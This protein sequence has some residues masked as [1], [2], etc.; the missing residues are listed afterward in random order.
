MK[1]YEKSYRIEAKE[2]SLASL[3]I[4]YIFDL[5]GC[6][7]NSDDF[8]LTNK[9]AYELDKEESHIPT[10]ENK[11]DFSIWYMKKHMMDIPPYLGILSLFVKLSMFSN[12][13]IVTSRF[14]DL[15]PATINW[16]K[17]VIIDNF[18]EEIWRRCKFQIIFN[19]N[20]E[21]SLKFKSRI[22]ENLKEFYKILL[23]VEDHPEVI[24]YAQKQGIEVLVPSTG[25]KNLNGKDLKKRKANVRK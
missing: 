5:D 7:A 18:N 16:L 23:M 20:Q 22:I 6:I 15:K 10:K 24:A 4:L 21:T 25:Y 1:K 13:V 17:Q 9:Q 11:D 3:P 8:V 2:D 19:E 12:V 14:E